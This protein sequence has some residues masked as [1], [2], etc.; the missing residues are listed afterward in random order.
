MEQLVRPFIPVNSFT[1]E[2]TIVVEPPFVPN[3]GARWGKPS[4]FE[5]SQ[6]GKQ[7]INRGPSVNVEQNDDDP[8]EESE[9]LEYEVSSSFFTVEKEEQAT[10][11]GIT[12]MTERMELKGERYI[13]TP[14][15]ANGV[16]QPPSK[17]KITYEFLVKLNED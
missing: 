4:K 8:P 11:A 12:R 9:I 6:Q 16:P 5:Y 10:V 14:P 1:R 2:P 15:N 13:D 3:V 17:Q 7:P